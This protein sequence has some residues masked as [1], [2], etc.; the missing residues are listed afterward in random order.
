MDEIASTQ[1]YLISNSDYQSRFRKG[2]RVQFD[3]Y[4]KGKVLGHLTRRFSSRSFIILIVLLDP[5]YRFS[6]WAPI[7]QWIENEKIQRIE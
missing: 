7:E 4:S 2:D 5:E 6:R 1:P 3:H